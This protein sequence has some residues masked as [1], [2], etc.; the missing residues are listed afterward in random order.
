MKTTRSARTARPSTPVATF[1]GATVTVTSPDDFDVAT[2]IAADG[3]YALVSGRRIGPFAT[4][5]DAYAA[6]VAALA[7]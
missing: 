1:V 6:G 5:F 3:V 4:V 2:D 7:A